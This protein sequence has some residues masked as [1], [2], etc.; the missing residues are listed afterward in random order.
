MS[1]LFD[2]DG[3][4]MTTLQADATLAAIATDG[5]W[6]DTAGWGATRFVLVSRI[7]GE[8][9]YEFQDLAWLLL[10][11]QVKAVLQDTSVVDLKTAAD[12]IEA[13]MLETALAPTGYTVIEQS[14]E[15]P[16]RY[17]EPDPTIPSL[18][19]QHGGGRY[20]V[21]VIPVPFVERRR[22]HR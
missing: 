15:T 10:V 9:E 19:W 12:R 4:V 14:L 16:I 17:S 7:T 2:V 18:R 11:Y 13:L 21:R 20:Q 5:V 3:A 8:P 6:F 22:V 1:S